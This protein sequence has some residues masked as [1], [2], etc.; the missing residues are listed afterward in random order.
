[1]LAYVVSY[2]LLFTATISYSQN[3]SKL[4]SVPVAIIAFF[5]S[6]GIF[7]TIVLQATSVSGTPY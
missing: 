3:L 1:M 2:V 7:M 4:K 6:A 5:V